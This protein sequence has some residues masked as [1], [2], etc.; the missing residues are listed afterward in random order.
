VLREAIANALAHRSYEAAGTAAD[1]GDLRPSAVVVRSPG[2]LREPV[3]VKNIRET[4]AAHNLVVIP[5]APSSWSGRGRE[6]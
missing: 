5:R 2:G 4:T 3:T 1:R 6:G